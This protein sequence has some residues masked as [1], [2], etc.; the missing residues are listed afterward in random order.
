MTNNGIF[1]WSVTVPFMIFMYALGIAG[2]IAIIK[3]AWR[4]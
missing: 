1:F 3:E 4:L 2:A